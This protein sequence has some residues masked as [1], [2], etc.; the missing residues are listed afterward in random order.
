MPNRFL[1]LTDGVAMIVTDLHGDRD[2][3]ARYVTRFHDLHAAGDVQRLIFLGDLIHGYGPPQHDK[4]LSIILDVI[5]LRDRLGPDT[6]IM[7]LGN[8]EMPHIYGASLAKGDLEFTPRFEH[9][10]GGHRETV[11]TF[12]DSLPLA[13]RTAAGVMLN[14]AGP[15][16]EVIDHVE[17]LRTF[18][19]Q[20]ILSD[21]DWTLAQAD[22]LGSYYQQYGA[23]HDLP[24]DEA[25]RHY[26]AITGPDDPRYNHL[27]RAFIIAHRSEDFQLLWD[28]LFTQNEIGL[29][30]FAYLQVV[31]AYLKAFSADAPAPQHV[32]ISGH[33]VTP[34]GGHALVN[35]HHLRL[36]SATHARP[37]E[38]G[39]YLLLDCAKPVR[40]ANELLT[41]LGTVFED[42]F[43]GKQ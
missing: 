15:A 42:F 36:S 35:R 6:V 8:H 7:V 9:A 20:D 33:I 38:A 30:E 39:N 2:A 21:A 5:A 29:A 1:D 43:E 37:R 4:S 40:A 31:Q 19:H 28:A 26:L 34:M 25:A 32:I 11:L 12:F 14:H 3:F 41:G 27:L 13:V 18:T 23:V 22:D 17:R 16:V 10:L 24:Y